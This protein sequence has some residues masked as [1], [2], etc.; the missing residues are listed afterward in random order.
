[1]EKIKKFQ[2]WVDEAQ[3]AAR[4]WRS[5]SW[6][7]AEMYD[8]GRA[9]WT[10]ED[11]EAAA[12][13]GIEP[14]TVNMTFPTINL[15]LGSQAVNKFD[16]IS[17]ARSTKDSEISQVMTE[18]VKFIMDQ[19]DGEFLISHAFRD[20]IIP[21]IGYLSPCLNPDPRKERLQIRRFD[22]KELWTDPFAPPWITPDN[23]RFAFIQRYMDLS[24]LQSMFPGKSQEIENTYD[25]MA[26]D[27]KEGGAMFEDEADFIEKSIRQ[28]SG[29]GW[30]QSER[31]RVRP[32]EMWYPINEKAAFALFADGRCVEMDDKIPISEQYQLITASQEVVVAMVKKMRVCSFFGDLELQDVPTPYPHDQFPLVPFVGYVDRY[33][34]PYG[35]PR[36]IRGQDTE[37]NKRRSMALAMLLKRRV[38]IESDA[39]DGKDALQT[40]YEEANKLDGLVVVNPGALGQKKI[41]IVEKAELAQGQILL[42]QEAKTEIQQVSG[43]NATRLGYETKAESGVA[44]KADIAQSNVITAPLFDNLR[45]SMK[46]LGDQSVANIQGFW[47]KEKVLRITDRMTGAEKFVEVN[48]QIQTETGVIELKNNITQGKYDTII[49]EAPQTDTVREQNM[50]LII[51]WVKKSPPE[52]IPHLMTMAF[53]M[54]NIPNKEQTLAKLKPILGVNPEDEDLT[55][56][57]MKQKTIKA[58]EEQQAENA[59]QAQIADAATQ[60]ELENKRLENEK[61]KVEIEKIAG[62]NVDAANKEKREE[63]KANL[64]AYLEGFKLVQGGKQ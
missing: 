59:K 38:M 40:V 22:W 54:S 58:L 34:F 51:E 52:I 46:A 25:D 44:K 36:Q 53:E 29:S 6:R 8:G 11:W 23:C 30:A 50:N 9:Q 19:S 15:I 35:V 64:D 18:G 41:Q 7:D 13:A 57:E 63:D 42:E 43:A 17:K 24:T 12:D 45:R 47:T 61:L 48:K 56:E 5:E 2:T 62:E 3:W 26:G 10:D 55:V 33:N 31:K 4:E 39:V 27:S 49:S 60:L 32:I 21:G 14:I 1:M 28:E 16:I 37:V 20:A